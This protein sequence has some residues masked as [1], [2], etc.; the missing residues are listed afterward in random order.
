MA[1]TGGPH[2]NELKRR[3][4]LGYGIRQIKEGNETRY[5][6]TAPAEPAFE[7]TMTSKGQGRFEIG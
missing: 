4:A 2:Y 5:F 6:A 3:R 1:A 7:A